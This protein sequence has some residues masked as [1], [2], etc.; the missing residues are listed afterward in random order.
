MGFVSVLLGIRAVWVL[1]FLRV[2]SIDPIVDSSWTL[3]YFVSQL[4]RSSVFVEKKRTHEKIEFVLVHKKL[5]ISCYYNF[6]HCEHI[7]LKIGSPTWRCY[8]FSTL[9]F[10]KTALINMTVHLVN[11]SHNENPTFPKII[12]H[13][14]FWLQQPQ[15]HNLCQLSW[16]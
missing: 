1:L 8:Q 2:V 9:Q 5:T 4:M 14:I 12:L 7:T 16:L 10:W 3:L 6:K 15:I 11:K 13:V